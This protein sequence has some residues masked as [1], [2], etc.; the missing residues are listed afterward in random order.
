MA[1]LR[2]PKISPKK[3]PQNLKFKKKLK[4]IN[5]RNDDIKWP[6][7]HDFPR[8]PQDFP[9]NIREILNFKIVLMLFIELI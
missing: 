4:N 7:F 1:I 6:N 9:K 5:F 3:N 8:F 2:F